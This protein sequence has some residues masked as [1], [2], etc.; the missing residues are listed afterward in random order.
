MPRDDRNLPACGT[1][2]R[3]LA[4]ITADALLATCGAGDCWAEPGRPCS[5][6]PGVHLA[7]YARARRRGQISDAD[8]CAVLDAAALGPL[9]VFMPETVVCET[10]GAAA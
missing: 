7:R 5:C 4:E 6:A 8:M 2:P 3:P 9:D 1:K 10:T